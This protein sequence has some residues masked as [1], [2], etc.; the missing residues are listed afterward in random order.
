[1]AVAVVRGEKG[2]AE[3]VERMHIH[4]GMQCHFGYHTIRPAGV[5]LLEEE[6]GSSAIEQ[7][8]AAEVA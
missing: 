8:L 6:G 4:C 1:M 7:V 3:V 2:E 5:R